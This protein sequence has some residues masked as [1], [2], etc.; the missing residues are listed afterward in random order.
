MHLPRVKDGDP[1]AVEDFNKLFEVAERCAL[2]VG[3]GSSI[4]LLSGPDGYVLSAAVSTPIW[5]KTTG[6]ISGGTY[7]FT[8]QFPAAGGTWTAGTL[9]DVAYE[10]NGNTSVPAD[11]YARAWRTAQGD[12]RFLAGDCS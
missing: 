9:T 10:A 11:T 6:A 4:H 1:I 7:P 2:S 5:I 8:E 12:W 3:Q